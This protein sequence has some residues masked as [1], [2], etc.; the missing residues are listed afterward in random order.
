MNCLNPSTGLVDFTTCSRF[1]PGAATKDVIDWPQ[2]SR[3]GYDMTPITTVI[4]AFAVGSLRALAEVGDAIGRADDANK[5]RVRA[6]T[7][8]CAITILVT[9]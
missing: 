1:P 5:L 2:N 8:I 4:N 9:R 7:K 6:N 3:D